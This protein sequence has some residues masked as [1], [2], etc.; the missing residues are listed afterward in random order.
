MKK[1][2]SLII[3]A[4][5][6]SGF[7]WGKSSSDRCEE[8]KQFAL[9]LTST[10]DRGSRLEA[11]ASI[12]ELCP[13]GAAAQ[14]MKG[15]AS[16][17]SGNSERALLSYREALRLDPAFYPANGRIGLILFEKNR[18][19]EASIEFTKAMRGHSD[20]L[21]NRGLARVFTEKKLHSLAIYHYLEALKS[22]PSDAG[23]LSGIA[24]A[25]NDSGETKKAEEAYRRAIAVNPGDKQTLVGLAALYTTSREFD[26]ALDQLKKAEA[27]TPHDKSIHALLADIYLKKGDRKSAESELIL[28]G[29][30][31]KIPLHVTAGKNGDSFFANR[32]FANAI[33]SYKAELNE[34]PENSELRQ[35]LGN[36][37]MSA[38]RDQEAIAA[39][40]E[41]IRLNA[42]NQELHYNL[43]LLYERKNLHDEAVVEYRR[44]LQVS[45]NV[46]ARNRLGDIYT[47]RGSLPQAIEQ[48]KMLLKNSPAD[49][50]LLMKLGKV[51]NSSN[52]SK[53]AIATFREAVR[54]NP[55]NIEAHRELAN[56]FKKG[57]MLDDAEK[58]YREL[59]RL[60]KDDMEVRNALTAIYVKKKN[61]DDLVTLLKENVE[62]NPR[63]PGHLYKLGLVYEFR[64]DYENA[65]ASYQES[66][67]IKEDN[68]KSLNALGR[69]KM[70]TGHIKEAKEYLERAK[71]ADPN[72]EE[73]ALLLG[74]IRDELTPTTSK[75]KKPKKKKGKKVKK[76]VKKPPAKSTAK[77]AATKPPVKKP[78]E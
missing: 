41:A 27:I 74:N 75:Y 25:Y 18:S 46:D 15:L 14:F 9:G 6:T 78:A 51:Y 22:Y 64:K 38:G 40:R 76:G 69:V 67:R 44:A 23:L 17:Q 47:Q 29:I 66:V 8:A 33:E 49:Q 21:Y 30:A 77:P 63:D 62:M 54:H 36:A 57:N 5:L 71:A 65:S 50:Q 34:N 43:G 2:I 56:H 73:T 39:Y 12:N 48:Y 72:L 37:F 42:E 32:D 4:T 26:K 31:P 1:I 68:A 55:D 16:E 58:E 7:T 70:K 53:E 61:Y 11:E 28:A 10:S 13:D 24:S 19:D 35:K 3:L 60:K 45:D 59:L 20:P 52:N